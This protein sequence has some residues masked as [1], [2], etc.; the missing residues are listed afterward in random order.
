MLLV[1]HTL[2]PFTTKT[3]IL[4]TTSLDTDLVPYCDRLKSGPSKE[5]SKCQAPEPVNVTLF[6]KRIFADV[7]KDSEIISAWILAGA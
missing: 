7:I 2:S 4:L 1:F 6:R 3:A 5:M